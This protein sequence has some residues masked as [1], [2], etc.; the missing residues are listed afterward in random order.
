MNGC[1]LC[2][3]STYLYMSMSIVFVLHYKLIVLLL[4]SNSVSV[5]KL[6]IYNIIFFTMSL[7]ND[8]VVQIYKK[9]IMDPSMEFIKKSVEISRSIV[10]KLTKAACIGKNYIII[11]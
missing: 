9:P 7:T 10:L 11:I 5:V 6:F 1:V 8:D 4:T 3:V 2:S